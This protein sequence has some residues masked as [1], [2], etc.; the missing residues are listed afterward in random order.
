MNALKEFNQIT[1]L[2]RRWNS[3]TYGNTYHSVVV[4]V[5]GEQVGKVDFTYGYDDQYIQTAHELLQKAGIY[6]KTNDRKNGC[7]QDWLNFRDD[8]CDNPTKFIISVT[9]VSRRKDL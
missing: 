2:G 6:P 5:D 1:I 9:N 7:A 4:F 3:K 8:R